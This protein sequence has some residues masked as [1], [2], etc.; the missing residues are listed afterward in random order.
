MRTSTE[1]A[2]P[3]FLAPGT[4]RVAGGL[5]PV[6]TTVFLHRGIKFIAR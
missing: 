3:E 6:Q 4:I 1:R 5:R 2:S